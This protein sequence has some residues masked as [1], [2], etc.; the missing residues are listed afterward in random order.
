MSPF[1]GWSLLAPSIQPAFSETSLGEADRPG[2]HRLGVTPFYD[3]LPVF[4]TEQTDP[5]F[6]QGQFTRVTPNS[7]GIHVDVTLLCG[8][9]F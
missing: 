6:F 3:D 7:F 2:C 5:I 1:I 8:A 4:E 9:H